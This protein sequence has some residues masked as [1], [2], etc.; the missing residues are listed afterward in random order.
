MVQ[1]ENE[2]GSY[3]NVQSNPSDKM[4]MEHLVQLARANLGEDVII[5][6]TDGGNLGYMSRGSLNGSA[7]Y[8]V[9]DF[10]PGSDQKAS[11]EVRAPCIFV[12]SLPVHTGGQ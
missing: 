11:F 4:Y 12:E 8:S 6:T 9:G 1:V 3:G 10:G 5:Y 2:F 7:V